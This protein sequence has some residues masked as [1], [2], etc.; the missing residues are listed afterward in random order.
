MIGL[1]FLLAGVVTDVPLEAPRVEVVATCQTPVS[2]TKSEKGR[3]F[4][5]FGKD[6]FGWLEICAPSG[7]SLTVCLGEKNDGLS[8]DRKPG[9]KIRVAEVKEVVA[10]GKW[11]R[12]PLVPD[13]LNTRGRS[14][15]TPPVP[16][17][18]R[19]GVVMPF[20]YV[21]VIGET[22]GSALSAGNFRRF[23]LHVP[24]DLKAS[25]FVSSD[26]TLN[27]V[28][29]LCKYSIFATSFAGIYV[30][31]DRERLPY[32]ADAYV[33]QISHYAVDSSLGMG[34]DTMRWLARHPTWPTE[35]A[36]YLIMMVWADW[37]QSG[38][39]DLAEEMYDLLKTKKLYPR[40]RDAEGLI[41]GNECDIVDWPVCE[42]DGF[43]GRPW[44]SK[45]PN[46]VVNA[47]HYRNLLEM[48]DL[49]EALG[50]TQD[51]VRFAD[52]AKAFLPVFN[53][54]FLSAETGL[55]T[56]RVG[57][58]HSSLHVNAAAVTCGL[59]PPER[60][61]GVAD[62]LEKKGMACSVFFAQHYLEALFKAGRA[63][64][65][66]RLMADKG[67]RS[68]YGMIRDG[69]TITTEAWNL[70]VKPNQDWNHAWATAPL[71]LI[72]RYVL[73]VRPTKP[74]F[75]EVEIAPQ[76]GD[77]QEVEG[78]VPTPHG[79]VR[80]K[81]SCGKVTYEVPPQIDVR[82]SAVSV[83]DFGARTEA[84]AT[85]NRAAI[86][87]AIDAA[88]KRGGRVTVP[89]GR[90]WTGSLQLKS[91]VELHLEKGAVLLGSTNRVDYNENTVF[92]ENAF[93]VAEEWS[94][95]HLVWAYRAHDIAITGEGV[96]DGNGPAFFGDCDE[97]SRFPY[98]KYG[99]KLHPLDTEWYRPGQMLAF[100]QVKNLRLEDVTLANTTAWTCYVRCS[101]GFVARRVK[102]L[103]D[104]TIANS[105]GFS[106]DCTRNVLVEKCTV[107]SGDDGFAIRASCGH[108]AATNACED[109]VIRDCDVWSCCYGVRFGIGSGDLRRVLVEN[110]R[111]HESANGFGF[112]P[113]WVKGE[114]GV[115]ISDI[116]V[117][118]CSSC[119]SERP[120][121][122]GPG[123]SR[124]CVR[125]IRFE[126]CRFEALAPSRI[127]GNDVC[128]VDGFVFTN[129]TYRRIGKVK[130]RQSG[131]GADSLE[132][133]RIF[134]ETNAWVKN[135]R[136]ENCVPG[137]VRP[138]VLVLAFDDRRFADWEKAMPLFAKYDAHATFFISG[139]IGADVIG[140][141]KRLVRAG[142]SVGLHGQHHL[143]APEAIREKGYAWYRS[144][145]IN[146]PRRQLQVSLLR[147]FA[148]AYPNNARTDETDKALLQDFRRLRAG[149]PGAAPYDPEGKKQSGRIPLHENDALFFPVDELRGRRVISGAIIGE[150]YHT[151]IDEVLKCLERAAKNREVVEFTSHGISPDAKRINM[152]TEWLEA[153]LAKAQ[154][155]GLE[156]LSFDELDRPNG[157]Q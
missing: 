1:V 26:E 53:R 19:Y 152:K 37:M 27:A 128:D 36:Q 30:D 118:N 146:H 87:R 4:V 103:A 50:R 63:K 3:V 33:N 29:S 84:D 153:I 129:C 101:D 54:R 77:L 88:A 136:F 144:S 47:F 48:R 72:T 38:R 154:E 14:P 105:D 17:A 7:V 130:V 96:I 59:C 116:T 2:V 78:Q 143:D 156:V 113:S 64:T 10:N 138:G 98:Y 89:P 148:F 24:M 20:R 123:S 90:W 73:G 83:V 124:G 132:R 133:A 127:V 13:E 68:W 131:M 40:E 58:R 125:D 112:M 70:K 6:A 12:V 126:N 9:G 32:E 22:V 135:A 60:L 137:P 5:D 62:F 157:G 151:R 155:L 34:R 142:H 23:V 51:A 71:N 91:G 81:V 150:A 31:G 52:E 134:A 11:R 104:R 18:D 45:D 100:Y 94:G 82:N 25:S 119:E 97:D 69:S 108:H 39:T 42:R 106:I 111:V 16:I 15:M 85:A 57:G 117:R 95:G 86:Q 145:E 79:S 115:H 65:A 107:R 41:V 92:P 46:G 149:V 140:S 109:I 141:V 55:Y 114:R 110:S 8:V 44:D 121:C 28:Y 66:I 49:A 67:D 139:E 61:T 74:G 122:I 80:V 75:A 120:V 56:D 35:W 76:V 93:S 21:E 147:T 99:L 102:I 43:E